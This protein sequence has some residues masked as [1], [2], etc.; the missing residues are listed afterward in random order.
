[1]SE[2][3]QE[4]K[5][6]IDSDW[7]EEAQREKDRLAEE[8]SKDSASAQGPIPDPTFHEILN[9]IV[10]QASI[11]LGGY[12][13]PEGQSVPPDLGAAK[14]Y[15][16]MLELLDKKTSGNLEEEEKKVLDQVIHEL[17]MAFVQIANAARGV[18]MPK[19]PMPKET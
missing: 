15:I 9:M 12:Q 2:E 19:D 4:K 10:M 6:I 8:E 11:G 5:I 7:K 1:M 14:H 3:N 18:P 16:D 17:R 13:S